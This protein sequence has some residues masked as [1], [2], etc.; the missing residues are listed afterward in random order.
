MLSRLLSIIGFTFMIASS[1]GQTNPA[2]Q[3]TDCL[4]KI[5]AYFP[6][7]GLDPSLSHL[8]I[9]ADLAAVRTKQKK[10]K[11]AE[12]MS[13]KKRKQEIKDL[14]VKDRFLGTLVELNVAEKR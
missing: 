7:F 14:Q 13:W 1:N 2:I 11:R 10:A 4:P 8:Q 12:F 9:Y 6:S 5:R 3:L